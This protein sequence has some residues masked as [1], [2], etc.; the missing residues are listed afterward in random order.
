MLS[1]LCKGFA[2]P[3]AWVVKRGEKGYS[4]EEMHLD[5]LKK[6]VYICPCDCRLVLLSDGEF[7][8]Q[9]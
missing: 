7:D 8:G 6:I 3:V 4:S 2:V 1:V 5:L 9:G